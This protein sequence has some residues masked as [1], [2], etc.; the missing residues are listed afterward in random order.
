MMG[1]IKIYSWADFD[2]DIAYLAEQ[3]KD[4]TFEAIFGMPRGGLVVAVALS[5]R[6]KLPLVQRC[7]HGN[8]I[9]WV[10]DIADSGRTIAHADVRR[11]CVAV[12]IQRVSCVGEVLHARMEF[13]SDWIVF[14]WEF[15]E[16]V[17][18]DRKEYEGHIA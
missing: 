7:G 5:H 12:L 16:S 9:L 2:T 8:R 14:P 17:E 6:L 15:A 18:Q 10:D 1:H 3:L 13:S 11:H 4:R